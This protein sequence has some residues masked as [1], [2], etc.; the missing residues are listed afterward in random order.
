MPRRRSKWGTPF[1]IEPR[2]LFAFSAH[3]AHL[4][5]TL[6]PTGM[7]PFREEL[8]DFQTTKGLL[9]I[10]YSDPLPEKL[11]R[12]IAKSRMRQVRERTDDGFW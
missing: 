1:F 8:K 4:S 11:I 6:M 10:P 3:K 12:K 2:F 5:F 9:K 7:E